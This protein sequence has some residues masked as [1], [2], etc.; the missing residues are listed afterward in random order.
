[1]VACIVRDVSEGLSS[2]V[3][4][5]GGYSL[6]FRGGF[7]NQLGNPAGRER[8][9]RESAKTVINILF[10]SKRW[11]VT[12][13]TNKQTKLKKAEKPKKNPKIQK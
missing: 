4:C 11:H 12:S 9:P 13:Q 6:H 2:A 3:G 8:L 1:M 5:R 10:K 7:C